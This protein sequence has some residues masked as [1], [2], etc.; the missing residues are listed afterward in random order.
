MSW[1][2][3]RARRSHRRRAVYPL[4][5]LF[6]LNAV[7]ELD[8]TAFGILL[9]EIRDHFGLDNQ[10][11]LSIVALIGAVS[12][13]LTIP[14]AHFADRGPRVKLALLGA[15]VWSV[16]SFATGLAW[17]LWFLVVARVGLVHRQGG[18]GPHPQLA[19]RGLLPPR[20]TA[21]VVLLPPGRQRRRGVPRTAD[22][23]GHRVQL[24]LARAV[25]RVRRPHDRRRC[26]GPAHEGAG[27]GRARAPR[28]GRQRRGGDDR[29]GPA[30]LRRGDAPLPPDREP[31][32]HLVGAAVLRRRDRG[33]R[34][35]REPLLR[36]GV[37][38]RR[39]R[40]WVRR[41]R[42]RAG[43]SSSA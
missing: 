36:G 38:A 17:A 26:A 33:L 15:V 11:I 12:L 30:Q 43:R 27:A 18:G 39:A 19:H 8:R 24:E 14:I 13:V 22:R 4:L 3:R 1:V 25:L 31:P 41:G 40:A 35:A 7:D 37:R 6:G 10:G 29:G 21:E 9:P 20:G 16:F 32:S 5:I 34:R 28:H 23:W 2:K 42:G